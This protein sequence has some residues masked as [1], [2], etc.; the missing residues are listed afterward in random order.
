VKDSQHEL[1]NLP[2]EANKHAIIDLNCLKA[3]LNAIEITS[4]MTITGAASCTCRKGRNPPLACTV[5]S[6]DLQHSYNGFEAQSIN[7]G[8]FGGTASSY[9]SLSGNIPEY[10]QRRKL[11]SSI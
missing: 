5:S 10:S 11:I 9:L 4:A 7:S 2:V 8:C 1:Y 6:E 3:P